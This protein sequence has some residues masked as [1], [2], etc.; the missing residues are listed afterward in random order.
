LTEGKENDARRKNVTKR[1]RKIEKGLDR[2]GEDTKWIKIKNRVKLTHQIK[3]KRQE[4]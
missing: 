1:K 3:T 2:E 4:Q